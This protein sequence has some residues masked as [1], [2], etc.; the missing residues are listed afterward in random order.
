LLASVSP[1]FWAFFILTS[2]A[3]M[4]LRRTD[5][6][7]TRPFRVPLYPLPPLL[8]CATSAY[9]LYSSVVYAR[10]LSLL[11]FGPVALGLVVYACSPR[12]IRD[13]R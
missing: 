5:A 7:R 9:M 4:V 13:F 11:G 1:T 2:V 8:F 3:L 10:G 12:R 6:G